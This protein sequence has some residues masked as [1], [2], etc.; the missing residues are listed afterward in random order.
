ME[1]P[2]TSKRNRNLPQQLTL[3]H[4][5]PATRLLEKRRQ[6]FEVQEA[7]D[8]QKEE[9]QRRETTF[10]RREEMLKNKD[11]DLQESLIKFNKFLQDNDSKRNRAEKKEKE[12]IKQRIIKEQEIIKLFEELRKQ[13]EKRQRMTNELEKMM[14]Y[15]SYLESVLDVADEFPEISDLLSRYDTL[16]AAHL[17]LISRSQQ[18]DQQQELQRFELQ[19][20]IREKS[21]E[22]LAYN[23]KI[24][25]LQKASEKTSEK[26]LEDQAEMEREISDFAD[27]KL[28][29]GQVVMACEN[30]YQRCCD[31]S[32]VQRKRL[33][34]QSDA[35]AEAVMQ[36]II[37]KLLFIRDYALDLTAITKGFRPPEPGKA[38]PTARREGGGVAMQTSATAATALGG[39]TVQP[40]SAQMGGSN[41]ATLKQA[42]GASQAA[43][44]GSQIASVSCDSRAGGC[45][46]GPPLSQ[47]GASGAGKPE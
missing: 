12:E 40:P 16:E 10:K 8:A 38:S 23:N 9:F 1:V 37:E 41:N 42:T 33:G 20:F 2:A 45:A 25:E 15:S 43:C 24:A 22:I 29:Y 28:Q 13:K 34:N 17:D 47:S 36:V 39:S 44:G 4:V 31:R 5:S 35:D 26:T 7:L 30:I 18:A 46:S 32:T 6:M 3:D 21:D 11:R 19:Q 14:K 27:R